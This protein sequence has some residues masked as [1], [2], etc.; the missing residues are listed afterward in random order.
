M[1]KSTGSDTDAFDKQN[2]L[3][4]VCIRGVGQEKQIEENHIVSS[5][6]GVLAASTHANDPII[7]GMKLEKATECTC[8][9]LIKPY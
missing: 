7:A 4:T 5:V 6:S 9:N 8:S 2:G 1:V 3:Y